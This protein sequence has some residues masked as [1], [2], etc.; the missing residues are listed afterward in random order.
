MPRFRAHLLHA[1]SITCMVF[2]A[3]CDEDLS[4]RE[5][6]ELA[7]ELVQEQRFDEAL[8]LVDA[9]VIMEGQASAVPMP[10]ELVAS[11]EPEALSCNDT[12]LDCNSGCFN[13][14]LGPTHAC[15]R[16]CYCIFTFCNGSSCFIEGQ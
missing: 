2:V 1:L 9:E 7:L 11:V 6:A 5:R 10:D 3:A 8:E 12:Y 13:E 14:P 4:R 15:M 16:T